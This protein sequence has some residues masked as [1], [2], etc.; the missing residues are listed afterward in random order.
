MWLGACF[1]FSVFLAYGHVASCTA[2]AMQ[3]WSGYCMASWTRVLWY[4]EF[5]TMKTRPWNTQWSEET[6]KQTKVFFSFMSPACPLFS[7]S[8]LHRIGFSCAVFLSPMHLQLEEI[9]LL[10]TSF[11]FLFLGCLY[12]F[13]FIISMLSLFPSIFFC[14]FSY[15]LFLPFFRSPAPS[16]THPLGSRVTSQ[17]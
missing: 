17:R 6:S 12:S 1:R 5:C 8:L 9:K 11:C 14:I 10:C 15:F 7:T 13:Y 16:H 4:G 2:Y 3:G